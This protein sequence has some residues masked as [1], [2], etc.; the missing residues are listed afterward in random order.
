MRLTACLAEH[1]AERKKEFSH[2][3]NVSSGSLEKCSS[4]DKNKKDGKCALIVRD[5][6][7]D[8]YAFYDTLFNQQAATLNPK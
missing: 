5:L 1:S 7:A 3:H 4:R 8:L 6:F 2:V